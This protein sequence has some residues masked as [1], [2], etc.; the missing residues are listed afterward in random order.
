MPDASG[1]YLLPWWCSMLLQTH[2]L[3]GS[4]SR[5]T[6]QK[7]SCIKHARLV[8]SS[9]RVWLCM[10][11]YLAGLHVVRRLMLTMSCVCSYNVQ[12]RASAVTRCCHPRHGAAGVGAALGTPQQ[13]PRLGSIWLADA[14]DP[15]CQC[16][17]GRRNC[18]VWRD[19]ASS[20]AR[21]TCAAT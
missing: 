9:A 10:S 20:H 18:Q 17:G 12:R 15:T 3:Y 5:R 21:W 6:R 4:V 2:W 7:T 1:H 16:Y 14:C 11:A 8:L 19:N 13:Q